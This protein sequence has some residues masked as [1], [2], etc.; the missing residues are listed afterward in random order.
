MTIDC[1]VEPLVGRQFSFKITE[2]VRFITAETVLLRHKPR[3]DSCPG[4]SGQNNAP[5]KRSAKGLS[6]C[7]RLDSRGQLSPTRFVT[8]RAECLTEFPAPRILNESYAKALHADHPA[9]LYADAGV[10]VAQ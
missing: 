10:W 4:L 2:L 5:L 8:F 1:S 3:G 9:M 7:A 6:S